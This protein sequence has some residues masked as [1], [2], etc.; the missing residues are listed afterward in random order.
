MV[1]VPPL[2]CTTSTRVVHGQHR[3]RE[4]RVLPPR[5]ALACSVLCE[6][7]HVLSRRPG[8]AWSWGRWVSS[9]A[10]RSV[11]MSGPPRGSLSSVACLRCTSSSTRALSSRT[12]SISRCTCKRR[13]ASASRSRS[14]S[15]AVSSL[16][17]LA[18]STPSE[19]STLRQLVYA[20]PQDGMAQRARL[21]QHAQPVRRC[22][23]RR[24]GHATQVERR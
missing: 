16:V 22:A 1:D 19:L 21:F 12:W 6:Q 9:Q 18:C 2:R 3:V 8:A 7:G 23:V 14:S 20:P 17:L 13:S 15:R 11:V 4:Q 24:L 10:R 5:L